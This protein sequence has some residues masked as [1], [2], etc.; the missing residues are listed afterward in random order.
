MARPAA[1]APQL[2]LRR[3][4]AKARPAQ[5]PR[6]HRSVLAK[7]VHMQDKTLAHAAHGAGALPTSTP[8]DARRQRD[9]RHKLSVQ[10]NCQQAQSQHTIALLNCCHSAFNCASQPGVLLD[11]GNVGLA[12]DQ[13]H[14]VYRGSAA[15]VHGKCGNLGAA[16]G[17]NNAAKCLSNAK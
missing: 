6:R 7:C 2:V 8:Y 9:Q 16:K 1:N 14:S 12:D 4:Q 10:S 11:R 5:S 3:L 17:C 15:S 13:V